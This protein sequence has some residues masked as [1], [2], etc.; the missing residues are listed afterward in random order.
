MIRGSLTADGGSLLFLYMA[1]MGVASASAMV[2]HRAS[3]VSPIALASS[4]LAEVAAELGEG[5]GRTMLKNRMEIRNLGMPILRFAMYIPNLRMAPVAFSM[6]VVK[7]R[8]R[9][10]MAATPQAG[11]TVPLG[12]LVAWVGWMGA[13]AI[14]GSL[15]G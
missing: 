2:I 11:V 7:G 4:G 9:R 10:L 1:G 8:R 13:K 12:F 6:K 3:R 14:L 5:S 15:L